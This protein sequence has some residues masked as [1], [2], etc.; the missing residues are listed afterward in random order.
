MDEQLK[1]DLG[2]IHKLI[3]KRIERLESRAES[4]SEHFPE[5]EDGMRSIKAGVA[6]EKAQAMREVLDDI[7]E[8]IEM[9]K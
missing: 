4:L 1:E 7:F 2:H 3:T 8:I 6:M 9:H 5:S